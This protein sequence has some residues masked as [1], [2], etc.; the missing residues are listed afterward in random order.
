MLAV[1]LDLALTQMLETDRSL[2]ASQSNTVPAASH[3]LAELP[4]HHANIEE[5]HNML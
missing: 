1:V 5:K 2:Q 3:L 4:L